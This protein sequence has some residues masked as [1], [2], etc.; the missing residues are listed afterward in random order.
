MK[1]IRE[2]ILLNCLLCIVV[3]TSIILEA[4]VFS[5]TT[6][7]DALLAPVGSLRAAI[8]AANADPNVPHVIK[9]AIPGREPHIIA[10]QA[11]YIITQERVTIDGYSQKGA[12]RNCLSLGDNASI[13]IIIDGAAQGFD[14]FTFN[15]T[16]IKSSIRGLNIRNFGNGV[17]GRAI[18]VLAEGVRIY[19]NFVGTN[20]SGSAL[21][22]QNIDNIF[23]GASGALIGSYYPADRNVI[24][25]ARDT[26]INVIASGTRI[27]GNYIGSNAGGNDVLGVTAISIEINGTTSDYI[28]NLQCN[29]G[30]VIVAGDQFDLHIDST[31]TVVSANKIGVNA[32]GSA[33]IGSP[34]VNLF[35]TGGRVVIGGGDKRSSNVIAGGKNN[36]YLN[37]GNRAESV[38]TR[39]RIGVD[40]SGMNVLG[41][42]SSPVTFLGPITLNK[43]VI[44]HSVADGTVVGL[45]VSRILSN[46]IG[47]N[48]Q[49]TALLGT[50]TTHVQ[51][52]DQSVISENVIA[53]PFATNSMSDAL[54]VQASS[55]RIIANKLGTNKCGDKVLG[56]PLFDII[57][58]AAGATIGGVLP[59]LKNII[60]SAG[61]GIVVNN[62]QSS[63]TIIGNHLGTSANGSCPLS[64]GTAI[65][66]AGTN[67]LIGGVAPADRN[68]IN[69]D[70]TGLG[71][72]S[73]SSNTTSILGNYIGTDAR[74][75]KALG[76]TIN[77]VGVMSGARV[78]AL[79]AGNL[80]SGCANYGIDVFSGTN[81][82][83][84]ANFIGTN[85]EGTKAIPNRAAGIIIEGATN[86]VVGGV[87]AASGN[88]ISGNQEGIIINKINGNPAINPLIAANFIGPD[89][90]GSDALGN[91]E[92]GIHVT[93]ANGYNIG[94]DLP[95]LPNVI[96]GNCGNGI[97]L[98][99]SSN[100]TIKNNYIG[101][102]VTG[103]R[104]LGNKG[105]GIQIGTAQG[106]SM[107]NTIRDNVI[108]ANRGYGIEIVTLP[109]TN[110]IMNNIIDKD[111]LN[112]LLLPNCKG[113]IGQAS[114]EIANVFDDEA[115]HQDL[116]KKLADLEK[117][118]QQLAAH[119]MKIAQKIDEGA[120]DF[121]EDAD[122]I[123]EN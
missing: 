46:H 21:V 30:N 106:S 60:A 101:V 54:I 86:T 94:A 69:G 56:N 88:V 102:D 15:A 2:K 104:P 82:Q 5:V 31:N 77:G 65:V 13:R 4:T 63:T 59:G 70:T 37:I 85:A 120:S 118:D 29:A 45:D 27:F 99:G 57:L 55:A 16:A 113:P 112:L 117:Q 32:E 62:F 23:I 28:G 74:G 91:K 61:T 122:D 12:R 51:L 11:P 7:A 9:F 72:I 49:G 17:S 83:I 47:V 93:T 38:I 39:N 97:L 75:E 44:A 26:N 18:V 115:S 64:L 3:A 6:T 79:G 25:G 81:C 109:N 1:V 92:N 95:A 80:I 116:E 78:G 66:D 41:A 121:D 108:S 68:I 98:D 73:T 42:T 43:N 103:Q 87:Q 58:L 22:G 40:V 35:D 76:I 110:I 33:P 96:S 111:V 36:N 19:G 52:L 48:A 34:L 123:E 114:V 105:N 100:D 10:P 20:E 89:S 50:G 119:I 84:Q 53:K 8:E 67:T 107:G 24:A 71:A 14:A 90:S